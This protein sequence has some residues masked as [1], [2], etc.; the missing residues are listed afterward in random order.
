MKFLITGGAGFIGSHLTESLLADQH[1]VAVIDDFSTGSPENLSSVSGN[2]Y[3][4]VIEEDITA[5]PHLEQLVREADCIIHL[6]AAVGVEL[7]VH[8]PVRTIR[9]NVEGT[10]KVL[11]YAAERSKRCIMASTFSFSSFRNSL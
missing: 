7:V 11:T 3:L 9:T 6:A 10:D 1:R 2:P 8:D 5:S 4:E